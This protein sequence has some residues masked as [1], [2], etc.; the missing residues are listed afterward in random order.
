MIDYCNKITGNEGLKQRQRY[1]KVSKQW[2][3]TLTTANILSGQKTARK[4]QR[5][6]KTIAMR[7][8][9]EL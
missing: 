3:A 9:R 4:S 7:L 5:Q 8:I 2:F 1:T 6:L